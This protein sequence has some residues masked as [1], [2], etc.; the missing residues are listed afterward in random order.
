PSTCTGCR[1]HRPGGI[2]ITMT[3]VGMHGAGHMGAGLGWALREGGARVVTT[4]AGRSARTARLAAEAGLEPLDSLDAV[5]EVADTVLV[6]TPPAAAR[7]AAGELAAALDRTGRRPLV[8]DLNAI[9][10]S[11]VDDIAGTLAATDFVEGSISGGP[12]TV[13]PGAR[14]CLIGDPAGAVA[15]LP[16]RRR[17]AAGRAVR[18]LRR[19]VPADHRRRTGRRRP[20]VGRPRDARPGGDPPA[21][22]ALRVA[23]A[24]SSTA[25]AQCLIQARTPSRVPVAN[26]FAAPRYS[27]SRARWPISGASRPRGSRPPAI[28]V[29]RAAARATTPDGPAKGRNASSSPCTIEASSSVGTVD[30]PATSDST[31]D[32]RGTT[33]GLTGRPSVPS[34]TTSRPAS[35]CTRAS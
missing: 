13:R 31:P 9:A 17:R 15:G 25:V 23:A 32:S 29:S 3:T 14:L 5:V 33:S 2:I 28:R 24:A 11:T 20:G 26:A 12:P 21:Q 18:G 27:G 22:P 8:A 30:M 4:L 6:V 7:D 19:G 34:A 16:W 35:T 10:P 1:I